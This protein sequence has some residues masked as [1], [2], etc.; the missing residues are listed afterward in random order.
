MGEFFF[1]S[2]FDAL[3]RKLVEVKKN[4]DFVFSL[5]Q[6]KK[7]KKKKLSSLRQ[8]R[9]EQDDQHPGR[10]PSEVRHVPDHR[11]AASDR[12]S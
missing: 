10:G 2:K 9:Q 8:P 3:V 12:S 7:K 1:V 4:R 11:P 5:L 6:K